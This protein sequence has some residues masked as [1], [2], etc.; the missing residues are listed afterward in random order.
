VLEKFCPVIWAALAAN[1]ATGVLVFLGHLYK[2]ATNP[3]YYAKL[4][5]IAVGVV[6]V[7]KITN[8][9]LRHSTGEGPWG[10]VRYGWP[11]H[12]RFLGS[13]R[14]RRVPTTAHRSPRFSIR[15]TAG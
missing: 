11:R 14:S 13:A 6:L 4:T 3:V 12:P 7:L 10:R 15:E 5:F 2:A 1:A 9:A 8:E